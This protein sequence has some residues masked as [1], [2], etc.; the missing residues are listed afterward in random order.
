[1]HR[2]S[3]EVDSVVLMW[4]I[5]VVWRSLV[6]GEWGGEGRGERTERIR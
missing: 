4:V 1:M 5:L 6:D 2:L 3:V